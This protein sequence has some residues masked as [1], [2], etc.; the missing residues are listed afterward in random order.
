[1]IPVMLLKDY[2]T[3]LGGGGNKAMCEHELDV[4]N[5]SLV[6]YDDGYES[7]NEI[8]EVEIGSN[9]F[10]LNEIRQMMLAQ[11]QEISRLRVQ[12]AQHNLRPLGI[13][14]SPAHVNQPAASEISNADPVIPENP[15]AH[16]VPIII[17]ALAIPPAPPARTPE[18][19]Y[20]KFRYMEALEFEG[21]MNPIEADN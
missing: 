6:D 12:L 8:D 13:G 19:L 5:N 21:S 20:D 18:E 4:I 14:V 7:D 17:E 2:P 1:M 11:Q 16:E 10:E 3:L 9:N 15:I